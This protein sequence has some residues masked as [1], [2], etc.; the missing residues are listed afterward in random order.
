MQLMLCWRRTVHQSSRDVVVGCQWIPAC[1]LQFRL[2]LYDR[3][4]H[5]SA[6]K[7]SVN[8][9]YM[10]HVFETCFIFKFEINNF[11]LNIKLVIIKHFIFKWSA[12]N[13]LKLHLRFCKRTVWDL[14]NVPY[15]IVN[16]LNVNNT[17]NLIRHMYSIFY[18]S[19]H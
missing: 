7:F 14:A 13:W 11:R 4:Q 18:S 1:P 8:F 15:D 3:S 6:S 5:A 9:N 17:T 10:Y 2:H 19:L 12:R 16:F